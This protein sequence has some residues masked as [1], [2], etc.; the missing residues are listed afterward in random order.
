MF[1][2]KEDEDL[3]KRLLSKCSK[4]FRKIICYDERGDEYMREDD[5]RTGFGHLILNMVK[6]SVNYLVRRITNIWLVLLCMGITPFIFTSCFLMCDIVEDDDSGQVMQ[7]IERGG[8]DLLSNV[9]LSDSRVYRPTREHHI[10]YVAVDSREEFLLHKDQ[11]SVKC[12]GKKKNFT[13]L[14]DDPSGK[15]LIRKK[16][17]EISLNKGRNRFQLW[18][19]SRKTTNDSITIEIY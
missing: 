17:K 4:D 2:K 10:I 7:L 14:V 15:T 3:V 8:R 9:A 18:F 13:I 11:L 12:N 6:R 1:F 5:T 16:S 19:K